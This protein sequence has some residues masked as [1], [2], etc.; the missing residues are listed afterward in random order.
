MPVDYFSPDGP[1]FYQKRGFAIGTDA[2]MLYAF[3]R[4][5]KAGKAVDFGCGSGIIGILLAR[6]R[7]GLLMTGIYISEDAVRAANDNA[8]LNGLKNRYEALR[9]DLRAPEVFLKPGGFDLAVMNPPYYPAGSGKTVSDS[10]TALART[11][12]TC[13]LRDAC[14]AAKWAVRWGGHFC[15]VHKPERTAEVLYTLHDCGLEPKRLRFVHSRA[16]AAP[17]LLLADAVRGAKPGL[18]IEAPL[19]LQNGDGTESEEIRQ[20]YHRAQSNEK[21]ENT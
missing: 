15:M 10:L 7:P 6:D 3:S 9:G 4:T 5:V 12:L 21:G 13:S 8:E 17:S 16:A 11:E 14:L 1:A 2:V 19:I 20:I 18:R